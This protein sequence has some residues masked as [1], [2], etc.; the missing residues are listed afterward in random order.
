MCKRFGDPY[1]CS[2]DFVLER[3]IKFSNK[4]SNCEII[5]IAESR[6]SKEDNMLQAAYTQTINNGTRY[7][8]SNQFLKLLPEK[9]EFRRKN[10]NI[11]GL[12]LADLVAMPISNK[13]LKPKEKNV[14]FEIIEN[15]FDRNWIGSIWGCGLKIFP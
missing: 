11:L 4:N 7:C 1:V 3:C 5:P 13:V 12:Q 8:K 15:K 14:P 9:I 2:L 6:G 10:E